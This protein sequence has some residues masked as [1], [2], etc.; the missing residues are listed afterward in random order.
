MKILRDHL[1]KKLSNKQ[2]S[3]GKKSCINLNANDTSDS[4]SAN[5]DAKLK[6]ELGVLKKILSTCRSCGPDISCKIDKDGNCHALS[7]MQLGL[8]ARQLVS[9]PI[10]ESLFHLHM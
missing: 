8:W 1:K 3:K 7:K 10:H 6:Q 9:I 5:L 2:G 4:D